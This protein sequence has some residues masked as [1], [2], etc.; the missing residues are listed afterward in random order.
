MKN[1]S[2]IGSILIGA[3][4]FLIVVIY[5]RYIVPMYVNPF[6]FS[7]D[8]PQLALLINI[9]ITI[10]VGAVAWNE[11]RIREGTSKK[12]KEEKLK[13]LNK[14]PLSDFGLAPKAEP[15]EAA[16]PIVARIPIEELINRKDPKVI[17]AL[18]RAHLRR[19]NIKT[20]VYGV[21]EIELGSIKMPVGSTNEST[22]IALNED[23]F[24]DIF[25]AESIDTEKTPI[26]IP[27]SSGLD[28]EDELEPMNDISP[29][30]KQREQVIKEKVQEI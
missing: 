15:E 11:V 7:R 5:W 3:V 16:A 22:E 23:D 10:L 2:R 13:D 4:A 27:I 20:T 26:P 25:K 14:L 21:E 12:L 18:F 17:E 9:V 24:K 30:Q 19:G 29:T 6:F 1:K 8:Y 28:I